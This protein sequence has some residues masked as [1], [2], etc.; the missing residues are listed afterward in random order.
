MTLDRSTFDDSGGICNKIHCY[1]LV[2]P[3]TSSGNIVVTYGTAKD[4][5]RI[6]ALTLTGVKEQASEAFG[7]FNGDPAADQDVSVT[8][9]TANSACVG[10][11]TASSS[12][13]FDI[14][15]ATQLGSG[16]GANINSMGAH[17]QGPTTPGAEFY[18]FSN[19]ST[20]RYSAL[21]VSFEI[22]PLTGTQDARKDINYSLPVSPFVG[23]AKLETISYSCPNVLVGRDGTTRVIQYAPQLQP[24]IGFL[25][26]IEIQY[27]SFYAVASDKDHETEAVN[28]L[29]SQFKGKENVEK[30]ARISGSRA[31]KIYNELLRLKY[32]RSLEFARK[33]QLDQLGSLIAAVRG[34]LTDSTYRDA[35]RARI[36]AL[37]SH[38]T[39][40][41]ILDIA[42]VLYGSGA[43][44]TVTPSFPKKVT[45]AVVGIDPSFLSFHQTLFDFAA[46]L[47]TQITLQFT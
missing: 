43:L 20:F 29:P 1:R 30:L 41:Q 11:V 14:T 23:R 35:I 42:R 19:S 12:T 44:V 39:T 16:A 15:N 45:I 24:V 22:A 46:P 7:I 2:N 27:D 47:G 28:R 33:K 18:T 40:E 38:G 17:E 25:R 34:N 21:Y 31:Q 6:M 8:T 36:K 9:V 32:L 37:T 5:V 4:N 26:P 13:S 10:G 3:S